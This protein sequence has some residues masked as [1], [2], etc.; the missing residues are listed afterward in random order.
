[1]WVSELM[2]YGTKRPC[3][4]C[5][6]PVGIRS[7]LLPSKLA[8]LFCYCKKSSWRLCMAPV[9]HFCRW[10]FP[11]LSFWN[12]RD[13]GVVSTCFMWKEFCGYRSLEEAVHH[14]SLLQNH[15]LNEH[16][17]ASAES[18]GEEFH[19]NAYLCVLKLMWLFKSFSHFLR[20]FERVSSRIF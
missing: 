1:M 16:I 15:S 8:A 17:K 5:F 14:I 3:L 9:W 18:C 2:K 4:Y 6:S 13:L 10:A 20:M 7:V 11:T 19:L 12:W